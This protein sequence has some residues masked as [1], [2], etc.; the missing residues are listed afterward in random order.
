MKITVL[1]IGLLFCKTI[2]CP[3]QDPK[4]MLPV[5][6]NEIVYGS[7]TSPDGK[8]LLS[9]GMSPELFLW[10][11]TTGKLLKSF[12]LPQA[13]ARWYNAY[14]SS[15]GEYIFAQSVDLTVGA[16]VWN[17]KTGVLVYSAKNFFHSMQ[18]EIFTYNP[19]RI[20]LLRSGKS[21][22]LEVGDLH[23]GSTI[24]QKEA[25]SIEIFKYVNKQ[26]WI[27][28]GDKISVWDILANKEVRR[29]NLKTVIPC[30]NDPYNCPFYFSQTGKYIF[31]EKQDSLNVVETLTG[32]IILQANIKSFSNDFY[33]D[34]S[35]LAYIINDNESILLWYEKKPV[36]SNLRQQLN[37]YDLLNKSKFSLQVSSPY[38]DVMNS[39]EAIQIRDSSF[40]ISTFEFAPGNAIQL[41]GQ[42]IEKR[43]L[44]TG[45]LEQCWPFKENILNYIIGHRYIIAATS[46]FLEKGMPVNSEKDS[47]RMI[48]LETGNLFTMNTNPAYL[49]NR[50][51]NESKELLAVVNK[52]ANKNSYEINCWNLKS[53]KK[54]SAMKGTDSKI[55]SI[56][57]F[58]DTT[59]LAG[60]RVF[61]ISK[62]AVKFHLPGT[63]HTLNNK[64]TAVLFRQDSALAQS[65]STVNGSLIGSYNGLIKETADNFLITT[66]DT[67][68]NIQTA[69]WNYLTGEKIAVLNGKYEECF[70]KDD[71]KGL[72]EY[73]LA[74]QKDKSPV[75]Y[76]I[77]KKKSFSFNGKYYE[78][79][80]NQKFLLT[81]D[82]DWFYVYDLATGKM[83]ERSDG[84]TY[85]TQLEELPGE[86]IT[87]LFPNNN[88]IKKILG[89]AGD[90]YVVAIY[91]GDSVMISS[92]NGNFRSPLLKLQY[93]AEDWEE[94]NIRQSHLKFSR[95]TLSADKKF[96]FYSVG[97]SACITDITNGDYYRIPKEYYEG[98]WRMEFLPKDS[99]LCL[100]TKAASYE[101]PVINLSVWN[102]ITG[103]KIYFTSASSLEFS[104]LFDTSP[105]NRWMATWYNNLVQIF[106]RQQGIPSL[107]YFLFDSTAYLLTDSKGHYDGTEAARKLLYLTCGN[108][109]IELDQV[110]DQLWVPNL[111]ERI[112]KGDN[113]NAKS[114]SDLNLCGLTPEVE[115]ASNSNQYYFKIRPRHGGLGNTILF[116]NGIE[117]KRFTSAQLA[118]TADGYELVIQKQELDKYFI[119]GRE[120]PVTV[121]AYTSD[122]NISSR[123][124]IIIEDKTAVASKTPP[125]LFAV[126]VGVS[127]YKGDDEFDLT[128]AA[129]D[130]VSLSA[131][132]SISARKLLNTDG[133]EHVFLYELTTAPNRYM[134]PEKNAIKKV[135]AEIG[136]KATANDILV[137]FFAGHGVMKALPGEKAQFYFMTSDAS[138]ASS[139]TDYKEVGISTAEL[140]EWM[141]PELIT[142]QKR[143][144][145]FDACNSGQA[146]NDFVKLGDAGQGYLAAR[147]DES[148][149]QVKAI[150]K[151]NEQA[152]F[153]ILSA[154]AS[155]QDAYEVDRY[156]QGLL[157]YALLKAV[158]EQPD[159]LQKGKYLD[160]SRWFNAA[161][162][163]VS[164]LVKEFNARQQPQ[165]VSNTNFNIGVVDDE[166]LT[167][168]V[169]PV[170][171]PVFTAS[172]F[173]NS[174]ENA[175]GDNLELSKLINVELNAMSARGAESRLV[176]I[177]GSNSPEAYSL[178]GRY[179]VKGSAITVRVSIRQNKIVKHRFELTGSKDK[180]SE[181]ATAISDKAAGLVK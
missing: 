133:K 173:I 6:H 70:Y 81:A 161:E 102:F 143:V 138:S 164:D 136:T 174:D 103:K 171:K 9:F 60:N 72:L 129:K 4:L 67:G 121:K 124:L 155:N 165:I 50:G 105:N 38:D 92:V 106:D 34:R 113:I 64:G 166:V 115:D 25:D 127:D 118:K 19:D 180:L 16:C 87:H 163:I 149:Q 89:V 44:Y 30:G 12:K 73:I 57:F 139:V 95:F 31:L 52:S 71:K 112:I 3:A 128:Y 63:F 47:L 69:I 41:K 61:D 26:L 66:I 59:L 130:A 18:T 62:G 177:M 37:G 86:T 96:L 146:I 117:V 99:L 142:A 13:G 170:E 144:L 114:I 104:D 101:D 122:N 29:F 147:G 108:E 137:I 80:D 83:V 159:I 151:L 10:E 39:N 82:E 22:R 169:L 93:L 35:Q 77:E 154:S 157:T 5:G 17:V 148:G 14:F 23:T 168:I 76:N 28:K 91:P 65:F 90:D 156:S 54:M 179:D 132:L 74:L 126:M 153:F 75:I 107:N 116:V 109:I 53:R 1:L 162:I 120:N 131:T 36:E 135:L 167:K 119:T 100:F 125:N 32:K 181:L 33:A 55:K 158:K 2:A 145:I 48:S 46:P 176:Y 123:G 51:L 84:D 56:R 21:G 141:K 20:V 111:A 140:A 85:K 178:S 79:A 160:L 45:K 58:D 7:V 11:T 40:F 88:R 8:Y 175:D 172:V 27:V 152:G 150:E 43:N 134:L 110:K 78:M 97:Q 98:L 49:D 24:F 94:N 15:N 68:N 42:T